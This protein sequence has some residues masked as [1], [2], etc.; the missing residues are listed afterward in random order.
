MKRTRR[1]HPY[2]PDGRTNFPVR[3]V[4]GV[5]LIFDERERIA[6]VG[7]G[8]EVYKP[9]YR[10]FQV[11]N[12]HTRPRHVFPRSWT[13]RVI[14]TRTKAQAERLERALILKHRP[15][16]NLNKLEGYELTDTLRELATKAENSP[17]AASN[18]PAPF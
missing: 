7:Y 6:Y 10:H 4:P 9:L 17:W 11:W 14:Y 3:N 5:Y 8:K 15:R 2:K 12:D 1:R 13:V 16:R 18:D